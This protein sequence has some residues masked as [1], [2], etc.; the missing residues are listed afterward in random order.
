M[1]ALRSHA[2]EGRLELRELEDRLEAA[3]AARTHG[4]LA[5]LTVD[6]PSPRR[7]HRRT[8]VPELRAYLVVMVLLVAVWLVT[9]AGYFWPVW[10]I[11]GWGV[12]LAMGGR[13]Q[14]RRHPLGLSSCS[15]RAT[16]SRA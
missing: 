11:L 4:E 6:L 1:G 5:A 15:R 9:G 2:A 14:G 8:R 3:L 12:P 7:L 16:A 13:R 10:P